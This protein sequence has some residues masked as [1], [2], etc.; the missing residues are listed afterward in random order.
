M[1][2]WQEILTAAAPILIAIGGAVRWLLT[3]YLNRIEA[4]EKTSADRYEKIATSFLTKLDELEAKAEVRRTEHLTDAKEFG[5]AMA[6]VASM[7]KTLPPGSQRPP[8]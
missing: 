4:L 1:T 6:S 8:S 7:L 5:K 2:L 3:W